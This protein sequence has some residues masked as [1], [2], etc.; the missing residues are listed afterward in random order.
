MPKKLP[1]GISDFARIIEQNYAYIDK[2]GFIEFL[3]N[4]NN[5]TQ[6][7]LRPR[8]F[9][10]SLF[11]SVLEYYYDMNAAGRFES[12]FS[13][14]Y[15]G[16]N[17][18]AE[19]G[20]YAVM[21][22][23]FSVLDTET[24]DSFR[25]SFLSEVQ[26]RVAAFLEKYRDVFPHSE[27]DVK[28]IRENNLGTGALSFVCAAADNAGVPIFVLI[29]EYDNFANDL[30]AM[31][32]TYKSEVEAGGLVRTF[33]KSLKAGTASAIKRIFMTGVSPMM[34]NDLTSGFNIATDYSLFPKYN[35]LFGFT[36]DKVEWIMAETGVDK[37]LIKI[38]MEAYYNGYMFNERGKDKV[39]NPQ[40]ILYLFNQVLQLGMQPKQVVDTNLQTD[41]A[42]LRRLAENPNNREKLLDIVLNGSVTANI[43]EKFS[44]EQL[45]RDEYFTSLMFYL[46]MLTIGGTDIGITKLI[47]P[48]YSVR[49]L[50]WEY[51]AAYARD[52]QEEADITNTSKL[53]G[54]VMEMARTGDISPYLEYFTESILKRLS[55]RDLQ[56]FDE[57][58][59]KGMMLAT[60]FVNGLYLPVSEYETINGY[61]DIYLQRHPANGEIRYEHVFEI[62]Y[63]KTG[64]A[65]A[66]IAA[67]FAEAEA[68]IEKYKKD[69]RFAGRDD[70]KFAAMVFRGKGDV[71]VR[72]G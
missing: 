29:D 34:V 61:P 14:L 9:G 42:R 41:Y 12:L 27:R 24:P 3:E 56:R 72:G 2:T 64:A 50:Y 26:N 8:R 33:Y 37:K 52:Q 22:F 58:Y 40:M 46:G 55:N 13:G 71:E 36:R 70:L 69:A 68:Q 62:K 19:R 45:N 5:P 25:R 4:E 57:K 15:I 6:L 60:L 18:T 28:N 30:I 16:K 23:D 49:T 38:D 51:A 59:V 35:E 44:L 1:Y 21:R 53:T 10:K 20:M 65:D 32:E 43:I 47:I 67:K 31:G 66:E 7:M 17:P 11:L 54:T 48:N 63:A 39:Y